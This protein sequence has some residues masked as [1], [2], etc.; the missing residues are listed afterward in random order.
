[1][2]TRPSPAQEPAA[3]VLRQ[4][5]QVLNTVKGHF[6]QVERK[7]G[8]GGAQVWALSAVREQP[9]LGVTDLARIMDIHQSTA[10]NLVRGLVERE[11]IEVRREAADKRAVQLHLRPKAL[12]I[13]KRAPGPF[14]G[15][16]PQALRQLDPA[17][18]RRLQRDLQ[19]LIDVMGSDEQAGQIPL[20]GL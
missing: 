9:G 13:L 15:V 8:L 5:R 11:L 1:M 20:S 18:L 2:A 17:T 12:Q 10:S 14:E 6:H 19:T 7:V 3:L 4:F 16:L